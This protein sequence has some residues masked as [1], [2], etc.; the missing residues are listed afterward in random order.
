MN[1]CA[2]MPNIEPKGLDIS[3][4]AP[5]HVVAAVIYSSTDS[6]KILIAKRP[7]HVH[8]GGLWE[9]PGGKVSDGE[10][11]EQ[12]LC[13]EL[14]EELDISIVSYQPLMQISHDYQDKQ[15]F[16]DIWSVTSFTGEAKGA[17]GQEC[18]WINIAELLHKNTS[19]QFPEANHAILKKLDSLRD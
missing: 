19:Y 9:F 18:R 3:C 10:T 12:A 5:V 14:L 13:R 4:N 17:E 11:P 6:H 16:L 7:Q 15:V 2:S 8:Q 1:M